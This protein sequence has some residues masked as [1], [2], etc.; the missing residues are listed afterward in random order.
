MVR[1]IKVRLVL[2]LRAE[3]MTG[4]AIAEAHGMSRRS[5]LA[6]FDAADTGGLSWADLAD[7]DDAEVYSRVFPGRGVH[8]SV[9]VLPDWERVHAELARVGVTLKLLHAEYVGACERQGGAAMSYDRFCKAYAGYVDVAGTASRVLHK[10]GATVEVDWSGKTMQLVDLAGVTTPVFLFVGCLPFSRYAFVE[11]ALDMRQETWLRAHVAMFEFFGGTVPRIVPDNLKT[12]VIKHPKE[13]EVVLNEAYR[14]LAAHYSAA[15][16][17]GRLRRPKDKPSV[18]NTVGHV[19]TWVIA[20]LRDRQFA[21]L[22]ELQEAVREQIT[23]YN[24]EPF[25]KRPGSRQAVFAAEEKPLLRPLPTVSYELSQWAHGRKV[26]RNGHVVWAR[27][28]YS[29]PHTLVRQSVDLKITARTL[30]VFRRGERVASHLLFPPRTVNEYRTL[31]AHG[32]AGGPHQAWD[33]ERCRQWAGRLGESTLTVINRIFESV[34]VEEQ[35]LGAALAV[36]RLSRKYGEERTE[37]ACRLALTSS[38]IYSPRYAHLAPILETRQ[39]I[40]GRRVPRFEAAEEEP[41][42]YV[43]G[44][45]YYAGAGQSGAAE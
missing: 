16:L 19:S 22:P 37:N 35:G 26:Q 23:A 45:D 12:G 6:V 7:L 33:G 2:Q 17:P 41:A 10:A 15:V 29:V 18:E 42:G 9:F 3:G 4:R 20:T 39:D 38:S 40:T 28:F 30:E 44:P 34:P 14:E 32:P 27:N 36:L 13:G 8:E 1:R 21:T 25:Q 31:D 24:R 43:R 5:V 11:P